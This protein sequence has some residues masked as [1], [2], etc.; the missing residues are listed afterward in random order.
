VTAS[1]TAPVKVKALKPKPVKK[2]KKHP[3][4]VSHHKPKTTG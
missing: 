3:K 2:K 1:D 4:V